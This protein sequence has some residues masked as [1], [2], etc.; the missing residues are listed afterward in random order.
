MR[1]KTARRG[2]GWEVVGVDC[3]VAFVLYASLYLSAWCGIWQWSCRPFC[4][5]RS[6]RGRHI[7]F[8]IEY[9]GISSFIIEYHGCVIKR[10]GCRKAAEK[11]EHEDV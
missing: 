2:Y 4:S 10:N 9:H 3:G 6:C 1:G 8:F 7:L 11:I 5:F